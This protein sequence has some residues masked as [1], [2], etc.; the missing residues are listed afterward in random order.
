[1]KHFINAHLRWCIFIGGI[2][3]VLN[4]YS[5]K[6][7]VNFTVSAKTADSRYNDVA[8]ETGGIHHVMLRSLVNWQITYEDWAEDNIPH[9]SLYLCLNYDMDNKGTYTTTLTDTIKELTLQELTK[10]R[11]LQANSVGKYRITIKPIRLTTN[12]DKELEL[13]PLDVLSVSKVFEFHEVPLYAPSFANGKTSLYEGE[14]VSL[15]VGALPNELNWNFSWSMDNEKTSGQEWTKT[16]SINE[17]RAEKTLSLSAVCLA[18]D[19]KTQW[20]EEAFDKVYTYTVYKKPVLSINLTAGKFKD[21]AYNSEIIERN[22]TSYL[23]E[24]AGERDITFAM[25][26]DKNN[27]Q[28]SKISYDIQNA[29][30]DF[31][32]TQSSESFNMRN[33]QFGRY[34][35]EVKNVVW[36]I[37]N[38]EELPSLDDV[39]YEYPSMTVELR[40]K[41]L[42]RTVSWHDKTVHMWSGNVPEPLTINPLEKAHKNGKYIWMIDNTPSSEGNNEQW[43]TSFYCADGQLVNK[44]VSLNTSYSDPQYSDIKW[45]EKEYKHTYKVYGTP[46]VKITNSDSF[47]ELTQEYNHYSK[48]SAYIDLNINGGYSTDW[49]YK[50]TKNQ[51]VVEGNNRKNYSYDLRENK[52]DTVY[53]D[54]IFVEFENKLP[55]NV[56][57]YKGNLTC[58]VKIWPEASVVVTLSDSIDVG[59]YEP[60]NYVHKL[61]MYEGYTRKVTVN[62]FGG[63]EESWTCKWYKENTLADNEISESEGILSVLGDEEFQIKATKSMTY[64][65]LTT[66]TLPNGKNLSRQYRIQIKMYAQPQVIAITQPGK[67]NLLAGVTYKDRMT[68]NIRNIGGYENGWTFTWTDNKGPIEAAEGSLAY[69]YIADNANEKPDT[70]VHKLTYA[71]TV[72]G[73]VGCQGEM[74]FVV[75]DYSTPQAST[76]NQDYTQEMRDADSRTFSVTPPMGG[77]PNG[78][79]YKW[80]RDYKDINTE[81]IKWDNKNNGHTQDFVIKLDEQ[82]QVFEKRVESHQYDFVYTN[83]DGEGQELVAP[84]VISFPVTVYRRPVKPTQIV[85]KGGGKSNLFI[86]MYHV[87]QNVLEQADILFDFYMADGEHLYTGKERTL[88]HR[89][90]QKGLRGRSLWEYDVDN[91]NIIDFY[92]Y[93]DPVGIGSMDETKAPDQMVSVSNDSGMSP[94]S[95]AAY[96]VTGEMVKKVDYA[97]QKDYNET[98]FLQ[99]VRKGMYVL[100]CLTGNQRVVKKVVVK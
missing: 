60:Y 93:S 88:F 19:G 30:T 14:K 66:N 7:D 81:W 6:L 84:E 31:T 42:M 10:N 95:V 29:D 24:G 94:I 86:L 32:E 48:E 63:N 5:L 65:C 35:V 89:G 83:L 17:V 18:P 43:T 82:G 54:T 9:D 72:D 59:R 25:S 8:I 97:M 11:I 100:H 26:Y 20:Y 36:K 16:F 99:D 96:S 76:M 49:T 62:M 64:V 57:P 92:C 70:I 80:R 45:Y 15:E 44:V 56:T 34:T 77:S 21:E 71:N 52:Q 90:G 74:E 53:C 22:S 23:L 3:F 79:Y 91:D 37:K 28:I 27:Y 41:P 47:D 69:E 46:V 58:Y 98:E 87:E 4:A 33:L 40:E 50:W 39:P 12:E 73:E 38:G 78:W 61:G 68:F 51:E 75:V 2:F 55:G 67:Y 13:L 1:M 85:E